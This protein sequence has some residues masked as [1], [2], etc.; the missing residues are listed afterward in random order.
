MRQWAFATAPVVACFCVYLLRNYQAHG[1]LSFRFG[2][3]DWIWKADGYHG[4]FALYE[5]PPTLTGVF[6]R[7]GP[8]WFAETIGGQ[9]AAMM[10]MVFLGQQS[11]E[12]VYPI[13]LGLP[14]LL[15][16]ARRA[17]FAVPAAWAAIGT[18]VFLCVFFH[19]E[20]RYLS[21]LIPILGV[22]LAGWITES[23]RGAIGTGLGRQLL[24]VAGVA[25]VLGVA[26]SIAAIP[27]MVASY[28]A[29]LDAI[30]P[31]LRCDDA[32]EFLRVQAPPAD[33]PG[34]AAAHRG[35]PEAA[36]RRAR[37]QGPAL[38]RTPP[39]GRAPDTRMKRPAAAQPQHPHLG[40]VR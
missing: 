21:I 16:H 2:P 38:R 26:V 30:P 3:I 36:R 40:S 1:D 22:A 14:A 35:C 33:P 12:Y 31:E 18:A 5:A 28:R 37:L 4:F 25:G 34:S 32:L 6:Q 10:R 8:L 24:R 20:I 39:R 13:A 17:D 23:V 27:R 7:Y 9:F 15:F 19:V 29:F 11:V